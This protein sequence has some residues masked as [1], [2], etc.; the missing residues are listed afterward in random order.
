MA[1]M[2]QTSPTDM[3]DVTHARRAQHHRP[4]SSS[5]ETMI[6]NTFLS[7]SPDPNSLDTSSCHRGTVADLRGENCQQP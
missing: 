5:A 4:L 2:A 1:V 3:I 6:R 7:I